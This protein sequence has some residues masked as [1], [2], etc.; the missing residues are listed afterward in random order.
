MLR[1]GAC[2]CGSVCRPT[3]HIC[4]WLVSFYVYVFCVSL[5]FKE[6]PQA[7]AYADS[8]SCILSFLQFHYMCLC[9]LCIIV[10]WGE[11]IF[12]F[13]GKAVLPLNCKW[14]P[15]ILPPGLLREQ[16]FTK[17][18]P[19]YQ[20]PIVSH[21]NICLHLILSEGRPGISDIPALSGITGLSFSICSLFYPV[22]GVLSGTLKK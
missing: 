15:R 18:L 4:F 6:K 22:A 11:F 12:L 3:S 5:F 20:V 14:T 13:F 16:W 1:L 2:V 21:I 10:L 9:F 7:K 8:I 17:W 19:C